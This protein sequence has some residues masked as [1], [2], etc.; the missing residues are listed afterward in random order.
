MTPLTCPYCNTAFDASDALDVDR[1]VCPRCGEAMP[2]KLLPPGRGPRKSGE[3]RPAP[4]ESKPGVRVLAIF[5]TLLLIAAFVGL[6]FWYFGSDQKNRI[7]GTNATVPPATRPPLA[8]PG[9]RYLPADAQVAIA[10]QPSPLLQYAE[11]AGKTPEEL[12]ADWGLP[13]AVF[14]GLKKAGVPLDRIDHLVLGAGFPDVGL[15]RLSI[16]LA[17]REPIRDESEFRRILNIR[18]NA[19]K[20]GR[21]KVELPG[22]PLPMEMHKVDDK[23]YLFSSDGATLDGMVKPKANAEFLPAGVR[24]SLGALDPAS[25]AWVATDNRDWANLPT[26][27]LI[28]PLIQQPDL[29]KRL[30][31]IRALAIGLTLRPDLAAQANIRFPDATAAGEF[32]A[33]A[34]PKLAETKIGM[35][36]EKDWVALDLPEGSSANGVPAVLGLF[37]R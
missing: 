29:P 2:A 20:P 19:D 7:E 26:L 34:K 11:R 10:L 16:V 25:F 27:K 37:D 4:M 30:K 18:Q 21:A 28:A 9:L 3:D 35:A 5:A 36:V 23:I 22:I 32:E 6:G 8:L 1:V 33:K 12:L 17:L 24:D 14:N 13:V 31:G 15:P